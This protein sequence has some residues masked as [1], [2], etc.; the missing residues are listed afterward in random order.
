MHQSNKRK[1]SLAQM[2]WIADIEARTGIVFRGTT[3]YE[4]SCFINQNK[5]INT[6]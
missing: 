4:A 2:S 3:M 5:S 1:P 6:I